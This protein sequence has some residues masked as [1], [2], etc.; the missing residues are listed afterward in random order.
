MIADIAAGHISIKYGFRGPNYATVFSMCIICKCPCRMHIIYIRLNK[1]DIFITGGSEAAICES[2][3][4]GFNAMHA[5]S[6][7]NDDPK[8]ASRPFDKDRDGF[9]LGE[10][11]AA[12]IFEELEHALNRGANIIAEVAGGGLSGDAYHMTAPHPEGLGAKNSMK[13]AIEDAEIKLEDN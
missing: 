6:T 1:A 4:G 8:T 13:Y 11:G 2:G 12:L 10:G 3:I 7:R 5:I 9:I